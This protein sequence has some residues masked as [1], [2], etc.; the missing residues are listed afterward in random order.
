[1]TEASGRRMPKDGVTAASE[2]EAARAA[3]RAP[4]IETIRNAIVAHWLRHEAGATVEDIVQYSG[5]SE[6]KIRKA[7]RA[8]A[9]RA[10]RGLDESQVPGCV[11]HPHGSWGGRG[12]GSYPATWTPTIELL[13]RMLR[14]EGRR[15]EGRPCRWI[16]EVGDP[17]ASRH[18]EVDAHTKEDAREEGLR[19]AKER[20]S[21][22]PLHANTRV[23]VEWRGSR[24]WKDGVP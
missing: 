18:F 16:V 7:L 1:M 13:T 23:K 14:G 17:G 4:I 21:I 19:R 5:L 8:T 10:W 12:N 2:V 9:V 6:H 11:T 24:P 22:Y 20:A 3:Q 15:G